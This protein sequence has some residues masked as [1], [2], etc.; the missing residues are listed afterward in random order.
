M[1]L[2]SA[3][4][5]IEMIISNLPE[6][7][8][9]PA[10]SKADNLTAICCEPVVWKTHWASTACYKGSFGHFLRCIIIFSLTEFYY[11]FQI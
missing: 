10:R 7:K 3:Q 2:W 4:P 1:A 11:L 8:G 5:L 9:W 6:G